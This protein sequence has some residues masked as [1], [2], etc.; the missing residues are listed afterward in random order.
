MHNHG[1]RQKGMKKY[2]IILINKVNGGA[3]QPVT[4][5]SGS[6]ITYFL[7]PSLV[8]IYLAIHQVGFP[9]KD[10]ENAEDLNLT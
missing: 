3:V 7:C 4:P 8:L 2:A 1:R 6:C 5:R 10:Q 9:S